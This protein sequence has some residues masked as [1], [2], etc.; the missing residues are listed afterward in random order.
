MKKPE[1]MILKNNR[2]M[3]TIPFLLVLIII[4][5]F[6]LSF[7]GLAMSFAHI[8]VVQYMS[9]SSARNYSL[10]GIS[11]S[12]QENETKIHYKNLR[13][14]FFDP[15]AHTG[16][17]GDWMSIDS[18][19]QR[20]VRNSFGDPGGFPNWNS[21]PARYTMFYGVSI[22]FVTNIVLLG[23]PFLSNRRHTTGQ[24]IRVSSFLGRQASQEECRSLNGRRANAIFQKYNLN[25]RNVSLIGGEDNAC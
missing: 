12:D 19:L 5:F 20:G 13:K 16:A 11:H 18:K 9:Y 25:P 21:N 17:P 23:I 1:I 22:L 15:T 8:S 2:G 7:F 14:T 24:R 6:I 10:G 3:V 4:L